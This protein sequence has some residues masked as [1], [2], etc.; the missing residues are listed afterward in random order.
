MKASKAQIRTY[1][2]RILE[3]IFKRHQELG[4]PETKEQVDTFL[5]SRVKINMSCI[6]MSSDE[7]QELI[8]QSQL[9]GD[10]IGLNLD[11]PKDALDDMLDFKDLK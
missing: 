9:Y 11:Y 1:K 10:T 3:P 5:K 7:I 6:E 4:Y 2:G 8:L